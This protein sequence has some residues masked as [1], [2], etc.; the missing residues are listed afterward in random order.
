MAM[1][2][3][4]EITSNRFPTCRWI[5]Q[6]PVERLFVEIGRRLPLMHTEKGSLSPR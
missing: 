6:M 5:M 4:I 2:T 3:R 1:I